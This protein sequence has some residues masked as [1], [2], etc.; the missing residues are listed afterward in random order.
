M[1]NAEVIAMPDCVHSGVDRSIHP[2]AA[3]STDAVGRSER[4]VDRMRRLQQRTRD[5]GLLGA[6]AG[7][8]AAGA[9]PRTAP[10]AE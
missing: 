8:L 3:Q 2:A 5:V 7:W 1:D 4:D 9:A 10:R 6:R